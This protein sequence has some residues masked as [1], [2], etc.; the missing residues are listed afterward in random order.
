MKMLRFRGIFFIFCCLEKQ[1]L[2]DGWPAP[3]S[4]YKQIV[5]D[6]LAAVV[7]VLMRWVTVFVN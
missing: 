1:T 2:I 5:R 4:T 7:K 3:L 6:D